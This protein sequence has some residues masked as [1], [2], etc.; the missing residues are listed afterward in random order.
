M[1][2]RRDQLGA[3]RALE[4]ACQEMLDAA[5]T[6]DWDEVARIEDSSRA[7]IDAIRARGTPAP[8]PRETRREKFALLRRIVQLDAEI[9]H[10][11]HPWQRD[12]DRMLS[13]G[14]S[15]GGPRSAG[16]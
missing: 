14:A 1:A 8:L 10:L 11:A 4:R 9:R 16:A 13:P 2:D 7:L 3:Y 12:L 6:G 5:R 15:F